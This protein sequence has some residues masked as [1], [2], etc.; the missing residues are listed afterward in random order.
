MQEEAMAKLYDEDKKNSS[1]G[2]ICAATGSGKRTRFNAGAD[3]V[4][5]D[6]EEEEE[7]GKKDGVKALVFCH[8]ENSRS[9]CSRKREVCS[10]SKWN[11]CFLMASGVTIA[12]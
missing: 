9:K 12:R 6:E 10:G 2:L 4:L 5:L 1:D 11:S 8:R 7:G 3:A